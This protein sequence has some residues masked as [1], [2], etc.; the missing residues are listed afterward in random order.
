MSSAK[1]GRGSRSDDDEDYQLPTAADARAQRREKARRAAARVVA[2]AAAAVREAA[3]RAE[4]EV[5][6]AAYE[7]RCA[8]RAAEERAREARELQ[9]R[10][11]RS[12]QSMLAGGALFE[13]CESLGEALRD[14]SNDTSAA[15]ALSCLP[16]D[17][18][19]RLGSVSRRWWRLLRTAPAALRE[20]R[21]TADVALA[22]RISAEVLCRLVRRSGAA[23]RVLDVSACSEIGVPQRSIVE[24]LEPAPDQEDTPGAGSQLE[25]LA[26]LELDA[27]SG[28]Q[29]DL[30]QRLRDA[31]PLLQRLTGNTSF[32]LRWNELPDLLELTRNC[33]PLGQLRLQVVGCFSP[34][35]LPLQPTD[36]MLHAC[37]VL[38]ASDAAFVTTLDLSR[39]IQTGGYH[40]KGAFR[41][42]GGM[43][44]VQLGGE[45]LMAVVRMLARNNSIVTM[46]LSSCVLD[47]DVARALAAALREN[48]S[49]RELTLSGA[50]LR[51]SE[52]EAAAIWQLL[53]AA[54]MTPVHDKSGLQLRELD[55]LLV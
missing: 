2:R 8:A 36:P 45:R 22:S 35:D 50:L 47:D 5:R 54:W 4:E 32:T 31:C 19:Q 6:R 14:P 1:R 21:F 33:T 30:V 7:E 3:R 16:I 42:K 41:G 39:N 40:G 43:R 24:S 11:D 18:R 23:L 12:W 52:D 51:S 27:S 10:Y 46:D 9:L 55:K 37:D 29:Y 34:T 38:A 49:L 53:R 48:R 44:H 15:K 25:E 28:Y 26:G 13:F 20:L 17:D